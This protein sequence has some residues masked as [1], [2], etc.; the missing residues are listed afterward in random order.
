MMSPIATRTRSHGPKAGARASAGPRANGPPIVSSETPAEPAAWASI[1]SLMATFTTDFL[2]CKVSQTDVREI[3]ERL[4]ADGHA[5]VQDAP[6]VA[7]VNTC[8]VTHEAVRK[9]RQAV[10]TV[11]AGVVASRAGMPAQERSAR[12]YGT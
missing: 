6:D 11:R 9:T 2:G 3:R 10:P 4:V 1:G 7:V 8:C 5:E 12:K